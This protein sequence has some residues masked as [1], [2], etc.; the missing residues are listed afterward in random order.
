MNSFK[1][2]LGAILVILGAIM[3]VYSSFTTL[4]NYNG[5][6]V[7][8]IVLMIAGFLLHIFLGKKQ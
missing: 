5:I 2:Y 7:G 8:A 4:K 6:L 3:I 1:R